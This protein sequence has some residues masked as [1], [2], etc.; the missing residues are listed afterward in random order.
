MVVGSGIID[1]WIAES[2]S[3]KEKRGVL[4]RI[5]TRARNKFNVSLAEVGENDHWKK[6]QIGFS[7][8]GN[9]QRY[10]NGKIDHLITFIDN[11]RIAEVV[12]T[13]IEISSLTDFPFAGSYEEGKY[14]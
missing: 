8:V 7:V 5:L 10:I 2:N 13:R 11:L 3:L 1:L 9:D 6:A 4:S 12:N 14:E